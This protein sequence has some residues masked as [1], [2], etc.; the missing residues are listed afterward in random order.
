MCVCAA[1]FGVCGFSLSLSLCVNA[2]ACVSVYMLLCPLADT[3]ATLHMFHDGK[4]EMT[5]Q[6]T[7]GMQVTHR[8]V[9]GAQPSYALSTVLLSARVRR[10]RRVPHDAVSLL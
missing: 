5:K 9:L 2:T 1:P 4:F 6:A 8:F 10:H 7:P 3:L